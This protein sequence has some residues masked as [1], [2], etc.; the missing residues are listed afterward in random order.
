LLFASVSIICGIPY[1]F[2][3]VAVEG[4]SVP[5]LVFT[6]TAIGAAML[7]PLAV[8]P[9]SWAAIRT[10]WRPVLVF[11][12]L[13]VIAAWFLLSDAER[14]LPSS[15]AG[16]LIAAAPIIAAVVDRLT[17][18]EQRL[19]IS[20]ILGLG[21]GLAG[22][23]VL[24][25]PGLTGGVVW[26]IIKVLLTATCYAIASLVA[27]RYLDDVPA[28][29]M[30]AACLGFA[31]LVYSAPAAFMWPR[32]MPSARVLSALAGLAVICT[33]VGLIVFFTLIR[34]VGAARAMV[35]TYISPAIAVVAGVILLGEP[36]TIWN[37]VAF[38]L[39]LVGSVLATRR[40]TNQLQR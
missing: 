27:A 21:V 38:A 39:I 4:V 19:G 7:L 36:L 33:A 28:L 31:A 25:G 15:M 30:T 23:A 18:G 8:S 29:P 32:E 20:R 34:E 14:H 16:L 2:I 17:G 11:A 22:V 35:F 13:E 6:R 1:L 9:G 26:P 3:K 5:V 37:I 10:R 40:P 12:F 24:A